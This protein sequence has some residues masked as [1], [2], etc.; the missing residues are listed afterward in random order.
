MSKIEIADAV[1]H[2]PSGEDW[3]VARVT[4]E[5]V[6]PAGWPPGRALLADCTLLK[7]ATDEQR[8]AM[9]VQ[10]RKLPMGDDRRL[11]DAR[12]LGDSNGR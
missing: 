11:S 5:H 8:E 7:K 2:G 3:V 10:L 4:E 9:M 6:Y 12:G 1:H